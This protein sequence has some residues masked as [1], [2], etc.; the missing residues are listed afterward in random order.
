M[1]RI[2]ARVH[3]YVPFRFVASTS[4]NST[5]FIRMRILSRVVPALLTRISTGP[6]ASPT[7]FTSASTSAASATSPFMASHSAPAS[8]TSF[9]VSWAAAS[10]ER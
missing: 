3:R 10:L 8:R 2:T 6:K 4:S 9:R 5:S 7:P 1:P